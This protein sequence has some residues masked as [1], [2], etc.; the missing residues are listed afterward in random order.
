LMDMFPT[1]DAKFY[2]GA[3]LWTYKTYLII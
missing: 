2:K 3:W 1:T